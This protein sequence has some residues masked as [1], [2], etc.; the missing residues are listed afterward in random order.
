[1]VPFFVLFV[2]FGPLWWVLIAVASIAIITALEQEEAAGAWSTTVL[3]ATIVLLSC[4][5]QPTLPALIVANPLWVIGSFI[6]C[7]LTGAAIYGLAEWW[8]FCHRVLEKY[9][10]VKLTWLRGKGISE[11]NVPENL[12]ADFRQYLISNYSSSSRGSW[13][14]RTGDE[15]TI[16]DE[17][18]REKTVPVYLVEIRPR[19]WDYA[20]KILLWMIYWPWSLFWSLF[21]NIIRSIFKRLR[22]ALVTMMDNVSKAVFKN[23][24]NDF[25]VKK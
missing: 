5:G 17:K 15:E 23:V 11:K 18:G 4:F 7:Y 22:K 8:L 13:V 20:D 24:D 9:E 2:L 12:T 19:P 10:N 3:V 16:V 25:V 6:A 1:M 14:R 21:H